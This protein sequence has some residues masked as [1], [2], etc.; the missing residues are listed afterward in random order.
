VFRRREEDGQL[1]LL[2]FRGVRA[3]VL[4]SSMGEQAGSAVIGE[5]LEGEVDLRFE[6]RERGGVASELLGPLFLLLCER[7]LKIL[8]GLL[9]R[10]DL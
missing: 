5:L 8:K 9:Q 1:A 10:R 4:S 7:S 6:L 2:F 3:G